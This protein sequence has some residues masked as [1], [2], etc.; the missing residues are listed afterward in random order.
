M[1]NIEHM[2]NNNQVSRQPSIKTQVLL[3]HT[4]LNIADYFTKILTRHNG[5]YDESF[6]FTIGLD[7]QVYQHFNPLHY[8]NLFRDER[9]DSQIISIGLENVGWVDRKMAQGDFFDWKDNIYEGRVIGKLW[10]GHNKWSE[11]SNLQIE[12]MLQLTSE[13][14]TEFHIKPNFTGN[15]LPLDDASGFQGVIN[16]SNYYKWYYDLSPAADFEYIMNMIKKM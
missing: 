16:R 11:Y 1:R 10:R 5:L 7:G 8:S 12:S 9:L 15:N 13:L 2:V 4:S 6:T 14:I 3:C